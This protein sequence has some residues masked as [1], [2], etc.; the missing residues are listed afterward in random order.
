MEIWS[1]FNHKGSF[2]GYSL[3]DDSIHVFLNYEKVGVFKTKEEALKK[4]KELIDLA[5]K[6]FEDFKDDYLSV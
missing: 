3:K 5:P 2:R 1:C 4:I 6:G